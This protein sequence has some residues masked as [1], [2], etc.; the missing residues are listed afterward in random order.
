MPASE[1]SEPAAPAQPDDV[2]RSARRL[3]RTALKGALATVD[4]ET[5]HPYAS[6]VLV[7][8]EPLPEGIT[9][10]DSKRRLWRDLRRLPELIEGAER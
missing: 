7:A 6:L 5:G 2:A 10:K 1:A 3:V 8:T 4:R 9:A